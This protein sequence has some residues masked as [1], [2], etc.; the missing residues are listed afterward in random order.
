M[1]E[2]VGP[3]IGRVATQNAESIRSDVVPTD[4]AGVARIG[5][6]TRD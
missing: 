6:A 2:R 5:A 4:R 1:R 3:S